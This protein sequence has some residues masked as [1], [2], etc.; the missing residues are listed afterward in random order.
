MNANQ[1]FTFIVIAIGLLF[2]GG[3]V[4]WSTWGASHW[5]PAGF[6]NERAQVPGTQ[7]IQDRLL[8]GRTPGGVASVSIEERE[9]IVKQLTG[10]SGV[11]S[12]EQQAIVNALTLPPN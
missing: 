1:K 8:S 10:S 4:W 12:S 3:I 6:R 9:A 2:I 5:F 7:T 11:T